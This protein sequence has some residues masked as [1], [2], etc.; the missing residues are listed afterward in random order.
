MT[1]KYTEYV[2]NKTSA[3]D[4]IDPFETVFARKSLATKTFIRVYN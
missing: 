3:K 1:D 2:K 4:M